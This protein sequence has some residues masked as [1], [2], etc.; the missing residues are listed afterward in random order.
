[1]GPFVARKVS[2][3]VAQIFLD[4]T[5]G[6]STDVNSPE[7][8][9]SESSGR[10]FITTRFVHVPPQHLTMEVDGSE[11]MQPGVI[12]VEVG[13]QFVRITCVEEWRT[14]IWVYAILKFWVLPI[15]STL[16]PPRLPRSLQGQDEVA[17]EKS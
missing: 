10:D 16:L 4:Q 15:L 9:T 6:I 2:A 14:G 7:V 5:S 8:K 13:S 3:Q 17:A 12:P 1:M 11:V